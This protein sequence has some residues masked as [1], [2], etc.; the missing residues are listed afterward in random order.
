MELGGGSGFL[1]VAVH[2]TPDNL[3]MVLGVAGRACRARCELDGG[4]NGKVGI[5]SRILDCILTIAERGG[6]SLRQ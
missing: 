3:D 2:H 4:G 5:F 1:V 6:K